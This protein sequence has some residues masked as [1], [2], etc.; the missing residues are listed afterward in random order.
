MYDRCRLIGMKANYPAIIQ[1]LLQFQARI[2]RQD[3]IYLIVD[4]RDPG[5]VPYWPAWWLSRCRLVGPYHENTDVL[6]ITANL[7]NGLWGVPYYWAGVFV[8]EVARFMYP[9]QRFGLV[10]NDCVPVTLFE[11]PDLLALATNQMQ[12]TDLVGM[13]P[14]DPKR[15]DKVGL[16]LVTEAHLEYNAGLVIS[17]GSQGRPSP[18]TSHSNADVL[19]EELA[20]YRSQL[21]V[22]ARPPVN[23]T[24]CS[25]GG[26]MFTPLVGVP[27]ENSLDLVTTW[28]MYGSFMC[29]TFWPMPMTHP[30][31]ASNPGE[32]LPIRWPKRAHPGALA[33][34]GQERTPWL[35]RWARATFEQGCLSALPHLEGTCKALSAAFLL[36]ACALSF[37]MLLGKPK[38]MPRRS[39]MTL[40]SLGG[41]RCRLQSWG[42][43]ITLQRGW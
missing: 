8:L 20:D 31:Q 29:R 21:L 6:W 35:T 34:A 27:M 3:M 24:D 23:P 37:F 42:C 13:A 41:K 12:W 26:T 4:N 14:D 38:M 19:A 22:M 40:H 5:E 32:G 28:A 10:D 39:S 1:C 36:I 18:I 11:V 33:E 9:Q 15:N 43:R 17:I 2:Q 16:L 25:Q 30:P 7:Q